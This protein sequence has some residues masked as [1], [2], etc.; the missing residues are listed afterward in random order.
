MGDRDNNKRPKPDHEAIEALLAADPRCE[1]DDSPDDPPESATRVTPD[2]L[3]RMLEAH[4]RFH[5]MEPE[6]EGETTIT[7]LG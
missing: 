3:E 7:F 1:K 6:E 4:P 2:G 5:K